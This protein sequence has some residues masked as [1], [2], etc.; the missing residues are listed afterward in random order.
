MKSLFVG[1]D[2]GTSAVKAGLFDATGDAL[3]LARSPYA[4]R[5]PRPHWVEQ[6]PEEWWA[7]ACGAL[8]E[9]LAGVDPGD[10]AAVGLSGQTPGHVLVAANGASLCPAII[11]SDQRA[12]E[13]A[14]WLAEHITAEQARAWTASS[15]IADV[16]QPP[17]RLLWLMRHC[18]DQWAR[19]AAVIQPKDFLAFRLTG[20][21][22]TD[23]QSS[24]CLYNP[25]TGRYDPEYLQT[26]DIAPDKMPPVLAPTDIVGHV[27][28]E[29][30]AATG[31]F[32]GTPVVCGTID[33]WCDIIGCGGVSPGQAVDVTGTSEVVALITGH[34]VAEE[35]AASPEA[36]GVLG[37]YLLEDLYW[38]GGPMQG[39][40]GTLLWWSGGFYDRQPD[41]QQLAAEA[42]AIPPGA[43]G[44]LFLPYLCGERAPV[45]DPQARGAFVGITDRHTRAHC[46]RAVYEGIAFAV[47]DVLERSQAAAGLR[48]ATLRVSGGPSRS[49]LW[50]QIKADVTGL[51]VQQM[52]VSDA[53]CL[54][55]AMLAAIGA[56]AHGNLAAAAAAMVRPAHL[57]VPEPGAAA[58]YNDLFGTWRMLYAALRPLFARLDAKR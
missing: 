49:G 53:A 47:R 3:H 46:A 19:C 31:L 28:P 20:R 55:A 35:A 7:A 16:T 56:R 8:R 23:Q 38:V 26:L 45:W 5:T 39:G 48:A 12:F 37:A 57:S 4:V 52:S 58:R 40:G 25:R 1:L 17:A 50:N 24:Y 33:A 22:A 18:A 34:P 30:A 15:F 32:A 27:T 42:A 14:A 54:G 41:L 51:P 10:V 44:L 11:W 2:L 21:I 43:D 36:A 29:A 6:E 9:T 13:E